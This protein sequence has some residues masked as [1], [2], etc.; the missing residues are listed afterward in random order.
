MTGTDP[1]ARLVDLPGGIFRMGGDD[2]DRYLDDGEG[3]VRDVK[4]SPF[5]I[6][7]TAVTTAE[8]AS[9]VEATGHRTTAEI[10]TWSF[11][12]GGHLP[13][14]FP[15]TR[16]VV[17][18]EWWRQVHGADWRHPEGPHSDL[19]GRAD[20]PVVHLSWF[21]AVAFSEWAG[22]RLPTEA[23]WEYAARGDLDQA[24]LPWGDDLMPGGEHRCNIWTGTFP[25]ED[26]AEDGYAGTCP[27]D[28]FAPNGFG[29]HNCSGNVWEWC[30]DYYHPEAYKVGGTIN[31]RGPEA[32]V[33]RVL[34]GGSWRIS[35]DQTPN[36]LSI[37][38]RN[39]S[40]PESATDARGFRCVRDSR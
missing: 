2:P 9:F 11:V 28:A 20:H 22:G 36:R 23:E 26:T 14:D 25:S 8:F 30:A 6:S 24:R 29:L 34:R 37:T 12:F 40:D 4:L 32:G 17:G 3:P 13:D 39:W 7:A 16:G 19:D 27:V 35:A 38:Y 5:A 15:E 18:A 31:P 10:E 21:D 33:Y 1:L